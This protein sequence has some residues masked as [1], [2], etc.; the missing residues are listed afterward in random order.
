MRRRQQ[1]LSLFSEFTTV[2]NLINLLKSIEK[3]FTVET[4]QV[5]SE[6]LARR[7]SFEHCAWV[8][9]EKQETM[10]LAREKKLFFMQR[11]LLAI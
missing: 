1:T 5:F 6:N 3:G 4:V 2:Q 11:D 7:V 8:A 9:S 10:V